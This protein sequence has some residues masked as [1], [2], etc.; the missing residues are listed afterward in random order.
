MYKVMVAFTFV[1]LSIAL[2]LHSSLLLLAGVLFIVSLLGYNLRTSRQ[3]M[4]YNKYNEAADI[5]ED[6]KINMRIT[7]EHGI[8]YIRPSSLLLIFSVTF[9]FLAIGFTDQVY[10]EISLVFLGIYTA[11]CFHERIV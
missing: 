4:T 6:K 9:L 2:Y 5:L 10:M 3:R 11:V 1:V 7:D 8:S